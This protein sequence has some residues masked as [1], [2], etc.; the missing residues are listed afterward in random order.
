MA[1]QVK[2]FTDR[3][4]RDHGLPGDQDAANMKN[5]SGDKLDPGAAKVAKPSD[6]GNKTESVELVDVSSIVSPKLFEVGLNC[7]KNTGG[8][9]KLSIRVCTKYILN[10][11]DGELTL[12]A[13]SCIGQ[14]GKGQFVTLKWQGEPDTKPSMKFKVEDTEELII[15][16]GSVRTLEKWKADP[17]AAVCY[18]KLIA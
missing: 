5:I 12:P 4:H 8:N 2:E 16:N 10:Q 13:F 17:S 3:F 15:V 14:F 9:L 1:E 11:T 18:N 6:E 7:V